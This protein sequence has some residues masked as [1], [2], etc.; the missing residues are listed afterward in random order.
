MI[1]FF[2]CAIAHGVSFMRWRKRT[3]AQKLTGWPHFG[4]F[5][6]LSCLGSTAGLVAYA[7]RMGNMSHIYISSDIGRFGNV[8]A[9]EQQ[10]KNEV[11]FKMLLFSAAHWALLPLELAL[12]IVAKLLV[13]QRMRRFASSSF[14]Q[15]RSW[16]LFG[17]VFFV[18]VN[19]CNL[20][21]FCGNIATSAYFSQAAQLY[22]EA[23]MAWAVN[24][25][26]AGKDL[27]M[28]AGAR[29]QLGVSIAAV[30]RFCEVAVLLMTVIL[31]LVVGLTCY[32]VIAKALRTL[33]FAQ[34]K[35]ESATGTV[36]NQD[37]KLFA[38]AKAQ[39]KRLQY[40]VVGTFAFVFVTVLVRSSFTIIY[41]LAQR[42]QDYGNTCSPSQCNPCK[43][44]YSHILFWIINTPS[45]QFIAMLISSPMALLVALWGMS[46]VSSLEQTA[47]EEIRMAEIGPL[48]GVNQSK[49]EGT[50]SAAGH[51]S[52]L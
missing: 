11:L 19:V 14:A 32:K 26:A 12:V 2:A 46:D 43:N 38:D 40:K 8:T 29:T 24:D 5:T 49:K 25:A 23:A 42:Y 13:L 44:M 48:T 22:K 7:A 37:R 39:G 10:E 15:G 47:R 34:K 17:R 9:A 21:G 30:Q 31:F 33:F 50:K 36:G 4:W 35:M 27:A 3:A 16:L 51:S 18:V 6:G 20:V 28:Q 41:A 1:F 45:V 52:L